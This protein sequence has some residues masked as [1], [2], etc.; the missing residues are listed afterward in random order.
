[1]SDDEALDLFAQAH[2][3][4]A[5]SCINQ[6]ISIKARYEHPAD[7]ALLDEVIAR[8][9]KALALR[10]LGHPDRSASCIDL[11]IS[12]KT[13]YERAGNAALLDEAIVLEREAFAL[14]PQGHPDHAMSCSNLASSL[15]TCYIRTGDDALLDEAIVLQRKALDLCPQRHPRRATS[16]GNLAQSLTTRYILTGDN[17]LIDEAIILECEAL[18]LC[19]QGHPYHGLSCGNLAITLK[20]HYGRTGDDTLLDEA[21]VLERKAL[22]LHPQGHPDRALACDNL[23]DSFALRYKSTGDNRCLHKILILTDEAR[24]IAPVHTVY[25]HL[26]TLCWVHLQWTS[27]FFDVKKA[28]QCLSRSCEYNPYDVSRAVSA[29]L[30][31]MDVIWNHDVENKHAELTY[32]YQ[33]IISLL[34]LLAYS[35]FD[36]QP[37]LLALK[38]C[39]HIGSDALISAALADKPMF[40]LELLELAQGVICSQS[41]YLRDPQLKDV[42]DSMATELEGHLQALVMRSTTNAYSSTQ[43]S[44][45]TLQDVMHIHSSRAYVLI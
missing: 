37:Q 15:T 40:G 43:E 8:K 42:P 14:C 16:C 9:R 35:A 41:L 26:C 38:G 29:F 22:D 1:M 11:A 17:A 36:V 18:A 19:P 33:C 45:L 39:S 4:R 21:I 13:C 3:D 20:R 2:P 5:Q 31:Y 32:I 7:N 25:R 30:H 24:I 27:S 34:P 6:A 10:P 28:I 44:A 12:L 23:T